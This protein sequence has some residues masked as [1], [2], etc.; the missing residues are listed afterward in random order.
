MDGLSSNAIKILQRCSDW[1]AQQRLVMNDSK[2][3]LVLFQNRPTIE[4]ISLYL[5]K[6]DSLNNEKHTKFLGLYV[7]SQMSWKTH[8]DN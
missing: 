4:N 5:N 3:A 6:N 8:V 2:T 7:D 1:F